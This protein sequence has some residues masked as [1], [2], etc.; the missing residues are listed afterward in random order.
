MLLY[1]RNL[2]HLQVTACAHIQV[3]ALIHQANHQHQA[4]SHCIGLKRTL[5]ASVNGHQPS[6]QAYRQAIVILQTH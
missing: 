3:M 2:L 5:R 1:L 6:L 4:L